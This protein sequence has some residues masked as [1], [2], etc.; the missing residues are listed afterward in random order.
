MLVAWALLLGGLIAVVFASDWLVDGAVALS[1]RLGLSPLVVGLTVIAYGTSLP[2]FVVSVLA[3]QNGVADIA[4]GNVVG[5]NIANFGLAWAA[6]LLVGTG[7]ISDSTV[8]RRDLPIVLLVS[9][10]FWLVCLDG[11]VSRYEGCGLLILAVLYTVLAIK[12]TPRQASEQTELESRLRIS[13]LLFVGF[14]GLGFGA[15]FMVDGA[16]QIARHYKVDERIIGLTVVAIGTSLPEIAAS[17]AAARKSEGAMTLGNILGSCFFNL[18]F[19]IGGASVILPME[20][21]SSSFGIDIIVMFGLTSLVAILLYATRR[22]SRLH[23]L[24]ILT[25]YGWFMHELWKS[26]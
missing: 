18:T 1:K 15:D 22:G 4:I 21:K 13:L 25:I 26:L 24:G 14:V 19:V 7:L 23:G 10:L 11:S 8:Y 17:V 3:A 6:A 9:G 2:E 5:S 20:V 16:T 12:S